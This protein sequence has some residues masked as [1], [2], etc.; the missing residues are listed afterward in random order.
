M[1]VTA[2]DIANY[3]WKV[4]EEKGKFKGINLR[5]KGKVDKDEMFRTFVSLMR[6]YGLRPEIRNMTGYVSGAPIQ[7]RDTSLKEFE[8]R[9]GYDNTRLVYLDVLARRSSL[10]AKLLGKVPPYVWLRA[11]RAKMMEV[12]ISDIDVPKSFEI[13]D[14]LSERLDLNIPTSLIRSDVDFL[15]DQKI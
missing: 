6:K 2:K 12:S 15:G 4:V 1:D 13:L 7:V 3:E 14:E 9:Y 8:T 11:G 10:K 5:Y